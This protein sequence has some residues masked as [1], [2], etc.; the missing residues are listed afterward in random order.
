MRSIEVGEQTYFRWRAEYGGMKTDQ[1]KQL[2]ELE[3][4]NARLLS[5]R[6][7]SLRP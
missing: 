3:S 4:E 1:L 7:R 5:C 2:K 6:R